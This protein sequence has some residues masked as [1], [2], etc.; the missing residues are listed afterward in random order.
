MYILNAALLFAITAIVL[1]GIMISEVLFAFGSY[2]SPEF[3]YTCTG[4]HKHC[5]LS[6]PQCGKA[7]SQIQT[8]KINYQQLYGDN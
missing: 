6:N 8:A 4:C 5:P 1:T 3:L 7:A 2:G